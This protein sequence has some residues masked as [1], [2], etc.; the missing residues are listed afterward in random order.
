MLAKP[1]VNRPL[2]PTYD[3]TRLVTLFT[4]AYVTASKAAPEARKSPP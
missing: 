2:V 3:S 1:K 4:Y